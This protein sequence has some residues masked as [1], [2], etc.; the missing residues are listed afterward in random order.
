[1]PINNKAIP[2][3][4][5]LISFE[6]SARSGSF[7]KAATELCVSVTAVSKQI[8]QLE[9]FLQTSL[10]IRR[11]TG[12]ELTENGKNYL[13]T[14]TGV[15][16]ILARETA[17]FNNGN[18]TAPLT[19]E[20]GACFSHFWLI[21]RLDG[22]R[23]R[24]PDIPLNLI[25]NNERH[26]G[27]ND[28]Y[29]IAFFYSAI[30][31]LNKN[32]HLLFAERMLLVCSPAFVA[33]RPECRDIHTIWQQPILMLKDAQSFWEGWQTWADRYGIPYQE[34]TNVIQMEEQVSIIQAA[35]SDA[36]IALAWDWHV[37][38]LIEEGQLIALT[39]PVE[40]DNNAFFLSISETSQ[41]PNARTFVNW[42]LEQEIQI[43]R[44]D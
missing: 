7:T 19:I 30:D 10:F 42:V 27:D 5:N 18:Q 2:P 43:S 3:I 31:T 39:G 23:E 25:I 21:P 11:K 28:D 33:K 16:E 15:L 4:S 1:M 13:A 36:G 22:F 17:K 44:F 6:A 29:D 14:V 20:I 38:T 37:R 26:I 34:P 12:L 35:L 41:H 24:Y 32:N 40:C 9:S 8:K